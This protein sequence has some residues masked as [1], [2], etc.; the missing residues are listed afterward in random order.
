MNTSQ[1]M[2]QTTLLVTI[3]FHGITVDARQSGEHALYGK[4]GYGRY[5]PNV[6]YR[7]LLELLDRL[8]VRATWFVPATEALRHPRCI[9]HIMHS[10]HEIG[11]NGVEM[12]SYADAR[13]EEEELLA[14]A[15]RILTDVAGDAPRGWRAPTGLLS[16]R[17]LPLLSELGYRYD[18]SFQDDFHPYS[19]ESDGGS[20]MVEIPQN[21]M[22]IDSTLWNVRATHDKVLKT[23]IEEFDAARQEN[24]LIHLTLHPRADSGSGRASRVDVVERFLNH[25]LSAGVPSKTARQIAESRAA[26][27]L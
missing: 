17:T 19:L 25:V 21:E 8:G 5:T 9:E 22:L 15:H 23:W 16:E 24:C 20:G 4:F 18:S 12:E 7:R 27:S 2:K 1:A 6:G 3:N 10:G 11:A 13:P 26:S 14:R